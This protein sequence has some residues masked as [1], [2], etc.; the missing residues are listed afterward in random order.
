MPFGYLF[1]LFQFYQEKPGTNYYKPLSFCTQQ[2][3]KQENTSD[4]KKNKK[5]RK[6]ALRLTIK[7]GRQEY[8][9]DVAC[10]K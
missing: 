4:Q 2:F 5:A 6:V 3:G 7:M 1:S 9:Q 10:L 8:I